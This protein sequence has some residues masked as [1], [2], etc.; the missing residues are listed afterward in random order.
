MSDI[1]TANVQV[2]HK[3]EN[4]TLNENKHHVHKKTKIVGYMTLLLMQFHIRM[5]LEKFA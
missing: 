2:C 5:I 3:P 4:V 1:L